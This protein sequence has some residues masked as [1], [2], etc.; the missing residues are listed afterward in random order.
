MNDL[1]NVVIVGGEKENPSRFFTQIE[2]TK[3]ADNLGMAVTSIFHG[4]VFNIHSGNNKIYYYLTLLDFVGPRRAGTVALPIGYP[5][6]SERVLTIP[7][8]NY[9]SVA[10]VCKAISK[11]IKNAHGLAKRKQRFSADAD[12]HNT[13]LTVDLN[14]LYLRIEGKTDTPWPMLGVEQDRFVPFLLENLNFQ[15]NCFPSFLYANIVENSYIDGRLSRNLGVV[16][17]CTNPRR[18][19]H[20]FAHPNY[21]AI[22]VKEFSKIVLELRDVNGEYIHFNPA[23]KTIITLHIKPINTT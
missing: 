23:Y 9:A 13:I 17:I 20:E 18:N 3:L 16:P 11:L 12:R 19:F 6:R 22:K 8:G 7:E 4:E 21:I 10:S 15:M 14:E 1:R 5:N 2:P